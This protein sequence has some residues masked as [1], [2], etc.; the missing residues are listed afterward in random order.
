M[1]NYDIANEHPPLFEHHDLAIDNYAG[2]ALDVPAQA[3][4]APPDPVCTDLTF[5][6]THV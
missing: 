1:A 3:Q 6:H 5:S 2:V 4:A